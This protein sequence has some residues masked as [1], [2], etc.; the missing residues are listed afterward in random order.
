MAQRD[1]KKRKPHMR[2]PKE[3]EEQVIQIDR[4]TKV[5]KGGRRLR[6]RATVA[7]GNKKGKVGIGIGKSNEVTGAIQKGIAKAKKYMITVP[8]DG[9]TIPHDIKNKYKSSII[10]LLPAAPG[11]GIIAGGTIRKVLELTG[12]KDIL[13]K[14][15]GTTNKVNNTKGIFEALSKLKVTPFMEKRANAKRAKQAEHPKN[16]KPKTEEK[17][18]EKIEEKSEVKGPKKEEPKKEEPKNTNQK[19]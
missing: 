1:F 16:E 3:F 12:V 19:A 2:E 13:S 4:V 15:Y 5:V 6:F 7:I 14:S 8:L 18:E 10:L 17:S 11:T 9:S